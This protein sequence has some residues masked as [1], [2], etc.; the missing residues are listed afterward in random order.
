MAFHTCLRKA[1][2]ELPS[3]KSGVNPVTIA[4]NFLS[5][6]IKNIH[7]RSSHIVGWS[8]TFLLVGDNLY[9]RL[10]RGISTGDIIPDWKSEY[11]KKNNKPD[12]YFSLIT[13]Q[14]FPPF[15]V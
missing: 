15:P 13:H 12:Y 14:S 9:I 5:P 2:I 1:F 8:D 4:D 7:M 11:E 6:I 3:I 10:V